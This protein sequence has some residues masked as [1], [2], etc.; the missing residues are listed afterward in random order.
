[1]KPTLIVTLSL[2]YDAPTGIVTSVYTQ[3]DRRKRLSKKPVEVGLE[4]WG[5]NVQGKFWLEA[6]QIDAPAKIAAAAAALGA[7]D[8]ISEMQGQL[9]ANPWHLLF[10]RN[11][12][13]PEADDALSA[14]AQPQEPAHVQQQQ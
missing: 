4:E 13:N 8:A 1:M 9:L 5:A 11:F 12:H 10:T 6:C 2:R 14:P 3:A 7:G